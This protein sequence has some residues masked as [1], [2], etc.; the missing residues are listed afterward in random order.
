MQ[1][2]TTLRSDRSALFTLLV[3]ALVFVAIGI[4]LLKVLPVLAWIDIV[5]FGACALI[6]LLSMMPNASYLHLTEKGFT[7]HS[8]F[9]SREYPWD[10]VS[11][12]GVWRAGFRK[13][14]GWN[15]SSAVSGLAGTNKAISGFAF[16]LPE[17]YGY[18]ADELAELLNALRDQ[19]AH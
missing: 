6:A 13:I 9:R 4:W 17:T 15:S 5:F 18:R 10:E 16:T 11:E 2:P 12:F 7:V 8:P 14:V 1:L 19:Y 3:I